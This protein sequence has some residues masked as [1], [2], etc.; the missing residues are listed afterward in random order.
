MDLNELSKKN[1]TGYQYWLENIRRYSGNN[2]IPDPQKLGIMYHQ[3]FTVKQVIDQSK[4]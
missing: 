2:K 4:E 3:G 1:G